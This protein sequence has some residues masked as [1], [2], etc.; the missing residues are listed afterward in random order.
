MLPLQIAV[1]LRSAASE[2]STQFSK[3]LLIRDL[4]NRAPEDWS[5]GPGDTHGRCHR[6]PDGVL[7]TCEGAGDAG[8]GRLTKRTIHFLAL[9]TQQG[10]DYLLIQ[11]ARA[12]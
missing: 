3:Q 8:Y 12:H 5:H 10:P 11:A 1:E 4:G 9:V 2:P 7:L 6:L